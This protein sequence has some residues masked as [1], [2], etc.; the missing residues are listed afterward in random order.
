MLKDAVDKTNSSKKLINLISTMTETSNWSSD[1]NQSNQHSSTQSANTNTDST[2]STT[3]TTTQE[4]SI[5]DTL[6]KDLESKLGMD[7]T[8]KATQP[9]G[10]ILL[11]WDLIEQLILSEK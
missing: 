3:T 7:K 2:T 10:L 6:K 11:I 4:P 8:K 1:T 9:A 5:W